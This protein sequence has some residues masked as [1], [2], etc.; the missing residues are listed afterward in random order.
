M[1]LFSHGTTLATNALI[2]RKFP[3]AVDGDDEGFRDVIEIRRG[4]RNDLWDTY[5]EIA[6]ALHPPPRSLGRDRARRLRRPASSRRSTRKRRA[7]WP[8]II[9]RRGIKT[10]AVCFINAFANPANEDRMREILMEEL[11]D[12]AVSISSEI[13]PEIFEHE[14]FSTTVANAVLSPVVGP[15]AERLSAADGQGRL[16]GRRAAAALRRR[17][18][19]GEDRGEDSPR[20]WPHPASPPA[21]SPAVT[22]RSLCGLRKL[23]RLRHGRHSHGRLAVPIAATCASP[24]SGTSSTAT[25]SASPRIE[26]LTIGAGG[27][28]IAWIDDA[29]SL[30]NGPQS[31]GAESRPGLLRARRA[32]CRPTPTPTSCW[33]AS[34]RRWPAA[35]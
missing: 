5:T 4:N 15:Y 18:D 31:A 27:G 13:M 29:G 7:R 21:R 35:R 9:G 2:T 34:A 16:Q 20:A 19:D 14:R 23:D 25:R 22:S 24:K 8:R 32:R 33:A 3:P 10:V 26:V 17:R 11:P 28:S 12:V 1:T 6:A 30:R